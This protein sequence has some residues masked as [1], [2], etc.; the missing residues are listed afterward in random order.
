MRSVSAMRR[1]DSAAAVPLARPIPYS[2]GTWMMTTER[3]WSAVSANA[4]MNSPCTESFAAI[5]NTW[6]PAAPSSRL[7]AVGEGA[8][9]I[10]MGAAHEGSWGDESAWVAD[11]D[12]AVELLAAELR[13]GDVVLVKASR[14][15]GLE[16]VAAAIID[17]DPAARADGSDA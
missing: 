10:H 8:R 9:P 15:G 3:A 16:R 2:S 5:R 4:P 12:A 1:V 6:G 14:A 7:V 17:L 11:A 13:P